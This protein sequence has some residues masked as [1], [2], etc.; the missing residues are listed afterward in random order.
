M[1]YMTEVIRP[2][3]IVK[4][5]D[6]FALVNKY[7]YDRNDLYVCTHAENDPSTFSTTYYYKLF[8]L[9]CYNYDEATDPS[10]ELNEE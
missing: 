5:T 7:K 10:L 6:P 8:E 4:A 3:N 9:G 1:P 2:M